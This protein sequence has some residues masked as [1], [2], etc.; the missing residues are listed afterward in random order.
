MY[1]CVGTEDSAVSR[2]SNMDPQNGT[3]G[4]GGKQSTVGEVSISQTPVTESIQAA[5]KA[6]DAAKAQELIKLSCEE[7]ALQVE[8]CQLLGIA[9]AYGDLQA[10][11]YLLKEAL[12]VLPTEPNDDNA[13]VVATY[14][15]HKDV[16]KELLDSL[17]G[18]NTCQQLL[19]WMLA[20]AC[21]QGHLDIV[22]LLVRAYSADPESCA[23]RRNEFPVLIRLPLYA[24]IKAGNED[25][26][27]FLLR[28]GAF[29]C[30]YILMDSPESSKHL[31]RKYFIETSPLPGSAPAKT[32]SSHLSI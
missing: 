18:P 29:F 12:V 2:E 30:S 6:G 21:Q 7:A 28:N 26:A 25:V 32:V 23:V 16:V 22:K 9:A 24:A 27:V 14:F 13:A 17:R 11:R 3:V 5:Y 4:M 8:K 10:V 19:N 31:L 1:W 20:I 15:G